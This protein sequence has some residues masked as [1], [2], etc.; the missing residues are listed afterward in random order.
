MTNDANYRI[1]YHANKNEIL[2]GYI[3]P[4]DDIL[5]TPKYNSNQEFTDSRMYLDSGHRENVNGKN[6]AIVNY[7]EDMEDNTNPTVKRQKL[8]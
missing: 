5:V 7:D 2:F 8:K 6:S 1:Q 3:N 4:D